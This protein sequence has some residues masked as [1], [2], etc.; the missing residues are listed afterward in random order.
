VEKYGSQIEFAKNIGEHEAIV[1]R[2]IRGHHELTT[3]ERL[4]WAIALGS[5]NPEILFQQNDK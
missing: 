1:S 2:V 3:E 5:N 4:K